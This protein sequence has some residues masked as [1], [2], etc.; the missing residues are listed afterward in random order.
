[1]EIQPGDEVL[2]GTLYF[3]VKK[4]HEEHVKTLRKGTITFYKLY[5][6]GHAPCYAHSVTKYKRKGV[7]YEVTTD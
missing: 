7:E 3:K 4:I 5:L 1:M 6:D 2:I